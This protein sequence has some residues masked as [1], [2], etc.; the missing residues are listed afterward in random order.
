MVGHYDPLPGKDGMKRVGLDFERIRYWL[1]VG[2]QPSDTVARLLGKA[3]ILPQFPRRKAA[4]HADRPA[5]APATSSVPE[6]EGKG[7]GSVL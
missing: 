1:S 6:S 2:A 4:Q 7:G 3:G 5:N